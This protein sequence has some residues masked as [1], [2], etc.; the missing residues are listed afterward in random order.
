VNRF[1]AAAL[2]AALMMSQIATAQLPIVRVKVEAVGEGNGFAFRR[3]GGDCFVVTP[4]HVI[5]LRDSS[6]D[7][8]AIQV[9]T[10][11][12]QTGFAGY[13]RAPKELEVAIIGLPATVRPSGRCESWPAPRPIELG[14]RGAVHFSDPS[15][16]TVVDSITVKR[17]DGSMIRVCGTDAANGGDLL[18]G[19]S[20]GTIFLDTSPGQPV[21]M[22]I[23]SLGDG[24]LRA[25]T[26]EAIARMFSDFIQSFAPP[27]QAALAGSVVLPGLGQ[28]NT[29][30]KG[31][32]AATALVTLAAMG[33]TAFV[34]TGEESQ[35]RT[36]NDF[37]GTPR[38]Y[39][40]QV[41][42]YPLR[43]ATLGV[44]LL[45]GAISAMDA[46]R[47]AHRRAID[48]KP[49]EQR[50]ATIRP[51]SSPGGRPGELAIEISF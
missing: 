28:W 32:G 2:V 47:H 41:K 1:A 7:P 21:A 43:R 35:T 36:V 40:I 14:N 42:N 49:R 15:G 22:V 34:I 4:R 37:F 33:T 39:P 48:A 31:W 18:Q 19:V 25:V 30:R 20:G 44:W 46:T 10:A 6:P 23:E 13:T 45:S 50:H 9:T 16:S 3:T 17:L 29:A 24:C 5:A 38:T 26:F 8:D 12:R 27:S 11:I 51:S